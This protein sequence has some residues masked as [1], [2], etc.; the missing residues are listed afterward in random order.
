MDEKIKEALKYGGIK[1]NNKNL[2]EAI[3]N[4]G[5]LSTNQPRVPYTSKG[6]IHQAMVK[7]DAEELRNIS[8]FYYKVNG[9][10][11]TVCNYFA[12]LYRYDWYMVPEV[13]DNK[14]KEETILKDYYNALH[15]LDS[16]HIK[17]LC[18]QIALEVILNGCYYGYLVPSD[19]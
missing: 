12:F 16:S 17:K 2:E 7:S 1:V 4:L 15:F 9:I 18:G 8:N 10:Y 11:Q 13:F 5:T 3:L 14:V 19:T 6:F